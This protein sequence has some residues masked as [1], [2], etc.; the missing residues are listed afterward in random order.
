MYKVES[1]SYFFLQVNKKR[2]RTVIITQGPGKIIVAI[3]NLEPQLF[4]VPFVDNIVDTNGAGDAFCGGWK[5]LIY[6]KF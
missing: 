4:D 6:N 1:F 3:N 2:E 5:F